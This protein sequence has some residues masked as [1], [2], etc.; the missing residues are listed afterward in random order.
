MATP[1]TVP[2]TAP[3]TQHR[4]AAASSKVA[5]TQKRE[6]GPSGSIETQVGGMR[7]ERGGK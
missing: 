5:H 4:A 1:P 6:P 7:W 3:D 2:R